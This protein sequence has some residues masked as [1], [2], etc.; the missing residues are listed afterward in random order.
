MYTF[1][2]LLFHLSHGLF[3]FSELPSLTLLLKQLLSQTFLLPS[4]YRFT[5]INCILYAKFGAVQS[6][7]V[8]QEFGPDDVM[9][10][11]FVRDSSV[12]EK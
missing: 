4:I 12:N 3:S 6:Q 1:R 10:S 7:L 8:I 11:N 5:K 2:G 9:C